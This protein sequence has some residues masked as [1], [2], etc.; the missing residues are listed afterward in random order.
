MSEDNKPKN[1]PLTG[2]PCSCR[3][4]SERNN[5]ARCE[6]SGHE[7]DWAEFHRQLPGYRFNLRLGDRR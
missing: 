7:I 4:G 2:K 6:G 1:V 3:P 5:C